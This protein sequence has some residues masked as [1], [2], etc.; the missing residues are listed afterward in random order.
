[1]ACDRTSHRAQADKAHCFHANSSLPSLTGYRLQVYRRSKME[2][3]TQIAID[4]GASWHQVAINF[5]MP[6]GF[7]TRMAIRA[8][9]ELIWD[10]CSTVNGTTMTKSPAMR[11]VISFAQIRD[12]AIGLR[13][14]EARAL[15]ETKDSRPNPAVITYSYLRHVPG[16]IGPSSCASS[17]SSKMLSRCPTRIDPKP[18]AGRIPEGSM[19][20]SPAL[21][22]SFACTRFTQLAIPCTRAR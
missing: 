5:L 12:S 10:S 11:E 17:K 16:R 1:M 7:D 8:K 3:S 4:D 2:V 22:V 18:R 20:S 15:P 6:I 13:R 9:G 14:T 19:I 21:T